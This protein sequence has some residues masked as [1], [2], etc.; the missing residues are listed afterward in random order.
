M[1]IARSFLIIVIVCIVSWAT[2]SIAS[3]RSKLV[4]MPQADQVEKIGKALDDNYEN[5][6]TSPEPVTEDTDTGIIQLDDGTLTH[7]SFLRHEGV[8]A[9]EVGR[10]MYHP[11]IKE[12]NE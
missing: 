4:D 8:G 6:L 11:N 9:P 1:V 7:S 5:L 2:I 10:S 12:L 3:P